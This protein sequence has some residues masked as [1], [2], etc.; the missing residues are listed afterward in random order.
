MKKS[1]YLVRFEQTLIGPMTFRKLTKNC[2]NKQIVISGEV[3]GDLGPWVFLNDEIQLGLH[4]PKI[5]HF[6][7]ENNLYHSKN[8]LFKT[9]KSMFT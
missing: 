3:T 1:Y 5:L 7:K 2:L 4:Y 9:I 8:K 6:L